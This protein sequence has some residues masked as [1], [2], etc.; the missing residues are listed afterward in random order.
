MKKQPES[1]PVVIAD[2]ASQEQSGAK[3]AE[4]VKRVSVEQ[5]LTR[6]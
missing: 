1:K 6:P 4:R 5:Y 3:N 2:I